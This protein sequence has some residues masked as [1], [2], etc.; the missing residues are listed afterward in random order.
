MF[1]KYKRTITLQKGFL[2]SVLALIIIDALI[3]TI[4][5]RMYFNSHLHLKYADLNNKLNNEIKEIVNNVDNIEDIEE[6]LDTYCE[7]N[8]VQIII[9]N[10]EDKPIY[11][12]TIDNDILEEVSKLI[13]IN[14]ETY[15]ITISKS[16]NAIVF[17]QIIG[18]LTFEVLLVG[19]L[20]LAG[21]YGANRK[22][23]GPINYLSK[24][25]NNYKFGIKPK[26]RKIKS[27]VDQCQNDFVDLVDTLEKEKQN[28]NRIIASI[29][30][31]IKTPLTSILGYSELLKKEQLPNETKISYVNKINTKAITM[32]EIIEEFDNYLSCNI[33][34]QT[35]S[36]K[37]N[38]KY[39]ISYLKNYYQEDLKEKNINLRIKTNCPNTNIFVDLPKFKRVFSN[40]ITNSIRHFNKKKK[41]IIITIIQKKD[42]IEFE[43]ADN[44]EGC[45]ELERIFE[46]LYTTDPS[47]KLGGLG[48]SI[49]KEIIESHEGTIK[50]SNNKYKGL[51]IIFTIK[52][53]KE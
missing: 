5:Y 47:R 29:S 16:R 49:C 3:L 40:I 46:P 4:Y 23:L 26:K 36:E 32:K 19:L 14:N 27:L 37:I 41:N 35:K 31:D 13:V 20:I 28:Q 30:H 15:L 24:D 18:L 33:K 44:G 39:L 12:N 42:I 1:K 10:S 43:I 2:Y 48:L 52:E 17:R 6:Y 25:M 21:L 53:Y 7:E 45:N 11:E 9:K 38:I 51:S 50:A 8:D 34:D 22:I